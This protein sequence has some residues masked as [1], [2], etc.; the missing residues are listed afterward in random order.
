[1]PV[2]RRFVTL[3]AGA[4]N[5]NIIQGSIYEFMSRPT[6]VQILARSATAVAAG[7]GTNIGVQFGSRTIA[8]QSQTVCPGGPIF[9][10]NA[11]PQMPEDMI[12]DDIAMPGE[13]IVISLQDRGAGDTTQVQVIFTE[14][15]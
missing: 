14:V 2:E 4:T 6:R 8:L 1:M 15:M 3:A 5:A 9:T 12:V 13:R 11:S 7:T 10:G